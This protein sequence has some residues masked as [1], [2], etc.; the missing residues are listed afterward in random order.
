MTKDKHQD[1]DTYEALM[2]CFVDMLK[3]QQRR[4]PHT[5]RNY[6]HTLTLFHAFLKDHLGDTPR[7]EHLA[8][9]EIRDFR[10]FLASRK[11]DGL[12]ASTLR[13][14]LSALRSFYR[15]LKKTRD[16][17]NP[18]VGKL[19]SP[20]LPARLP[21][22]LAR[23]Q[24]EEVRTLLSDRHQQ[25]DD[26]QA[27][28]DLA[29]VTLLYGAGLRISEALS[30]QWRD[31]PFGD[32]LRVTGKGDK[33]RLVPLLPA[34][35]AAIAKYRTALWADAEASLYPE[36]W[37]EAGEPAPLFFSAR[38]KKLSPRMAQKTM[39]HLRSQLGLPQSATPHALRHSFATHLLSASGD[40]RAIQE[41]LGHSSLAA[42][43]RYTAVDNEELLR[44]YKSAHPRAR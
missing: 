23:Q 24:T 20:K 9:L 26:W 3:S 43:Q 32:S 6:T 18:E 27:A 37:D 1:R 8:E 40:L 28:R 33:T 5:L 41:L 12:A 16:L 11:N 29:L 25:S 14:D 42:T 2:A 21:R 4:S 10:A 31:A 36:R 35:H 44:A 30:L 19:R 22:P 34:I 13:G 38:G 17:D 7:L 39:Q 15:H